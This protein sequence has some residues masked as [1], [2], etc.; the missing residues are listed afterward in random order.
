M[1]SIS[2]QNMIRK[3]FLTAIVTC[4]WLTTVLAGGQAVDTV[5]VTVDS[6]A[7]L[8]QK[9]QESDS[10]IRIQLQSELANAAGNK[11][12]TRELEEK[13]R[14]ISVKDSVR[15]AKRLGYIKK[16]RQ[17]E[18][19]FAVVPFND[20]LFYIFLN[21]GSF[22]AKERAGRISNQIRKIAEEPSFNV[23]SL[24]INQTEFGYDIVSEKGFVIMTVTQLD[25]L[26]FDKTNKQLAAEYLD[27]IKAEVR[28]ETESNSTYNKFKRIGLAILIA[29]GLVIAFNRIKWLF[30]RIT[31]FLDANKSRYFK[32][33]SI[34]K[35]RILK[36]EHIEIFVFRA[37]KILRTVL[38]LLAV[39]ISLSLI[40][41]IFP[42][43][44]IVTK[45]IIGWVV[46]PAK[47]L[48]LGIY[49]YLP[50]LFS[51]LV[52]FFIFRY[53]L[54]VAKYFVNEIETGN[55]ALQGFHAEWAQP[56]FNIVKFLLYAFMIVL[57]WPFLPGSN[58]AA[59]QGVSVFVGIIFSLGSSSAISNMV[60][61][62]VI[63]Y[64]RAFKVGDRVQIGEITGDIIEKTALVTR[65]RTIK[66][67]DITVP[68]STVLSSN[69][70]NYSSNTR[71]EDKGL[72]LHTTVTIGY[73]VPWKNMHEALI[74]AALRT[75]FLLSEPSPFVLQTSLDDFFVS[76]QVN[77]YTKEANKQA[78]IYSD[79]HQNIQDCCNEAGIE[80]LSPHYRNLRDG[81]ATSI[82]AN[83]LG[84]DYK[85]P[86]FKVDTNK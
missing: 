60:A 79:L 23:D 52:I 32:G 77:A 45:T 24:R 64:M 50:N 85:A 55:I 2:F 42:S 57:I 5:S 51:I 49:H 48:L 75:K 16:L 74:K 17:T 27:K 1:T 36:P 63:T 38:I 25:G 14:Q 13:L 82:P 39:V 53:S 21:V 76:Y 22:S 59:F 66:N 72:I 61:G 9:E 56:T 6:T 86:A 12:R 70:I 67:E 29:L 26:W 78:D 62:I 83:Y 41:D 80:I 3:F 40:F 18:K 73:D 84:D 47:G 15:A 44:R 19:G 11:K 81:N 35:T 31:F 8:N 43:T 28:T 68:N 69:T 58:S 34:G 20:T 46:D 71:P 4:I 30:R 33:L 7:T 10:L 65:I 54:K 37:I